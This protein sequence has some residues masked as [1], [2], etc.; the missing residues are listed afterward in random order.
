[1]EFRAWSPRKSESVYVKNMT[2]LGGDLKRSKLKAISHG[3]RRPRDPSTE[4]RGMPRGDMNGILRTPT[5][6][7]GHKNNFYD[8]FRAIPWVHHKIINGWF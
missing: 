2:G 7:N 5:N 8:R 4:C 1:M 6:L 3:F